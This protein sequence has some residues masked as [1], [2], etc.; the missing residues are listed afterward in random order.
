MKYLIF[1]LLASLSIQSLAETKAKEEPKDIVLSRNCRKADRAC[2]SMDADVLD[3]KIIVDQKKIG[4]E[5]EYTVKVYGK[6]DKQ[7]EKEHLVK[8]VGSD[9]GCTA[10]GHAT[11]AVLGF[12]S[13]GNPILM[14][15]DGNL[16]LTS[17]LFTVG[18]NNIQIVNLKTSK[19]ESYL[20]RSRNTDRSMISKVHFDANGNIY[21]LDGL[22]CFEFGKNALFRKVDLKKCES[23]KSEVEDVTK[24][25]HIRL[26]DNQKA[27][28]I[29]DSNYILILDS[30]SC[31]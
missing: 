15:E 14:T 30:G 29:K 13:A 5:T 7:P 16:E 3:K 26:K 20:S 17:R 21:Y 25:D 1:I 8:L 28:E 9:A 22:E 23:K 18:A 24:F 2:V 12:T 31:S 4:N 11:V 10:F 19:R 6:F 27:Y